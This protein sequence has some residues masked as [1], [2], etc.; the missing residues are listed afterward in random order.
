MLVFLYLLD[1]ALRELS[2]VGAQ[3]F[4]ARRESQAFEIIGR[5]RGIAIFRELQRVR[6]IEVIKGQLMI[7]RSGGC[8]SSLPARR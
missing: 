6:D 3:I 7:K 4:A 2:P 5:Q 1:V 8:P